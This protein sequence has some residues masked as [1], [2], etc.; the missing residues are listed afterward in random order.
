MVES[1]GAAPKRQKRSR[2]KVALPLANSVEQAVIATDLEGRVVFWNAAAERL[3]G[4]KWQE[5]LGR[6]SVQLTVPASGR[7]TAS[8]IMDQL[9]KGKS[10]S[11]KFSVCRRDGSEFI[12]NVTVK[13]IQDNKGNLVGMIG[14]SQP[15]PNIAP[16]RAL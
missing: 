12:A 9:R 6:Q 10:W 8:K 14:R 13:P 3:Y 1:L 7:S 11:G 16:N 2:S 4:W 5:A 15:K